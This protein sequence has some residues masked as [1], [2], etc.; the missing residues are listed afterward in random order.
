MKSQNHEQHLI[1]DFLIIGAVR[2]HIG[3]YS[4]A[5][6]EMTG[7]LL[8][9]WKLIHPITKRIII[10]DLHEAIVK[11]DIARQ[12][13]QSHGLPLG[14]DS[15]RAAWERVYKM[16]LS[17]YQPFETLTGDQHEAKANH[18]KPKR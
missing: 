11:D 3:K 14:Q 9:N 18:S 13:G 4:Y 6:S 8:K 2:Y 15:D 1:P 7:W 5:V 10:D 12:I 16:G 17:D